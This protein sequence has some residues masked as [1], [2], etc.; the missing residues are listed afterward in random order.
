MLDWVITLLPI[1]IGGI[2]A[3]VNSKSVSEY[4]CKF[5]NWLSEKKGT[6]AAKKGKVSRFF[7]KPLVFSLFKISQWTES[8]T[9]PGLRS[10]IR[11]ACY[12]YIVGVAG[13]IAATA[14]YLIVLIVIVLLLLWLGLWLLENM[15]D[16][17]KTEKV[18]YVSRDNK[19]YDPETGERIIKQDGKTYR[20]TGWT[21]K[22]VP[23]TGW[24]GK[25]KVETDWTGKPKIET[26]WT[27]K[28]KIETDWKGKP[29][30]PPDK[31]TDK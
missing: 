30:V 23:D 12:L 1:I 25:P 17:S 5:K 26:D 15:G 22:W 29:I 21:G 27:G 11:V 3:L 9:H 28:Q 7:F 19:K 8:I 20:Q 13:F 10:G 14:I 16:S 6:L 18:E 24:T 4:D 2:L 31:K